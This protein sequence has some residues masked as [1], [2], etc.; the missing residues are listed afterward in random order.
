MYRWKKYSKMQLK[1]LTARNTTSQ[2]HAGATNCSVH[3][4]G[5]PYRRI[6]SNPVRV[7]STVKAK[8]GSENSSC[9]ASPWAEGLSIW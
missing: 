2:V 4:E 7:A 9:L 6:A 8:S 3:T 5:N 1:R